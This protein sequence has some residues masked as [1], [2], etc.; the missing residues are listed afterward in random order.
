MQI[1]RTLVAGELGGWIRWEPRQGGG[2]EVTV[3][4]RLDD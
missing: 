3:C 4:A 2:T 1:V